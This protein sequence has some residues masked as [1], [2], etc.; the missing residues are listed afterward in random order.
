MNHKFIKLS[1]LSIFILLIVTGSA[2]AQNPGPA[3]LSSLGTAFTYQGRLSQNGSPANGAFDFEFYLFDTLIGGNQI[4]AP[5]NINDITLAN[6]YFTVQ[7][8]FGA[9][10]FSGDARFLEVHVRPY[11]TGDFTTLSPR[12]ELTATPNALYSLSAPWSGLIGVPD[13]QNRVSSYCDPGNSIRVINQDGTVTCQAVG[14]G[15]ITAVYTGTGLLGGGVSGDVTLS[16]DTTY[17]QRRVGSA[18]AQGS[19]I[20]V[21]NSDGTVVCEPD[22][23]TTYTA[24][25][26]LILN[27]GE[28]SIDTTTIQARVSGACSSGYAIRQVNADGSV[29][30]EPVSGGGGDITAVYAGTGLAGGGDHGDVTLSMANSFMLPQTCSNGQLPKWNSSTNLWECKNDNDTTYSAGAG[31]LLNGTTFSTDTSYMQRR[32]SSSCSPGSS[33]RLINIDGTVVCE[34][35]NDTS[36]WSLTG[37]AGTNPTNNYLG[38]SDNQPLELRVNGQ[39]VLRLEPSSDSPNL[40]GGYSGNS[41]TAGAYGSTIAGGGSSS[42]GS[43]SIIAD[44]SFIGGGVNNVAGLAGPNLPWYITI[45]GG[46]NNLASAAYAT[47]TGGENNVASGMA[48]FATGSQNIASGASSYAVGT[49]NAASGMQSFAIG[50]QNV[51]N[52]TE[53]FAAG[54]QA[55][56]VTQGSFVWADTYPSVFNPFSESGPQGVNN[57]FNIRATGGIYL[58]TAV[59][60]GNNP[61]AGVWVAGGGSG[62]NSYSDPSYKQNLNLVNNQ[63]ILTRLAAV[64]IASWS[65]KSQDTSIRHIGPMAPAFNAAFGVGEPDKAGDLKYINSLDADGVALASIQALYQRSQEQAAQIHALQDQLAQAQKPVVSS[66]TSNLPVVWIAVSGFL[67]LLVIFQAVMFFTIRRSPGWNGGWS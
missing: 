67:G 30:C 63:E 17:L 19:S 50:T 45:D 12:Q 4:G 32:V 41:V 9:G 15:D 56:A 14:T 8:D 27:G 18:C 33:I 24:G 65:Y 10:V 60:A 51:A 16:A 2:S 5:V 23:D 57:S 20:R 40:L 49:Q 1:I 3:L 11:N 48:S 47:I 37:N 39:R 53:S 43:N 38:T 28:F 44:Y 46:H 7:L 31:L 66:P 52:G 61:S 13:L 21:I 34:T 26:G 25:F 35:D 29:T 6:G 64:P 36:F 42:L 55:I 22:G 59:D 54:T 62:W 58:V